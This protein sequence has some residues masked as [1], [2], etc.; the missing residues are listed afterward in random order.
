MKNLIILVIVFF[1]IKED[2]SAQCSAKFD[3]LRVYSMSYYSESA[4]KIDASLL[5]TQGDTTVIT[6]TA[7]INRIFNGL[8]RMKR[9][10]SHGY[11]RKLRKNFE[12][13]SI[14][15]RAV[16]VFYNSLSQKSIGISHQS[17]MFIDNEVFEK[18]DI[19]LE[20]IVKPSVALY[21]NLFPTREEIINR[22]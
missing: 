3:S 16:F 8:L 10:T 18:K 12:K 9:K 1:V 2:V 6:D 4:I 15:V 13:Y 20:D 14:D 11:L 17:L 7:I 21:K 5:M 22:N 19:G